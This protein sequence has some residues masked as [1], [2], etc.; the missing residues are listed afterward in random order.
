MKNKIAILDSSDKYT[1][2]LILK[3]TPITKKARLTPKRLA[4]MIIG[5]GITSQE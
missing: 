3:F 2:W 5:D 1:H 4:K